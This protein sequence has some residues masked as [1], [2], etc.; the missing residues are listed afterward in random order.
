MWR[1][2]ALSISRARCE[3][4][5]LEGRS[6]PCAALSANIHGMPPGSSFKDICSAT[7]CCCRGKL[8]VSCK[9]KNGKCRQLPSGYLWLSD[10]LKT[11]LGDA[12]KKVGRKV[13]CMEYQVPVAELGN[14]HTSSHLI[15]TVTLRSISPN[16]PGIN[17]VNL[18][19]RGQVTFPRWAGLEVGPRPGLPQRPS[20]SCSSLA[21]TPAPW[22]MAGGGSR[23]AFLRQVRKLDA[24]GPAGHQRG[25]EPGKGAQKSTK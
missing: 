2:Q 16:L 18:T 1:G 10:P 13:I 3:E 8:L 15:F 11:R 22:P 7:L 12:R 24:T 23:P 19:Q 17:L 20:S 9:S 6:A 21:S 25:T 14:L 4:A 5:E